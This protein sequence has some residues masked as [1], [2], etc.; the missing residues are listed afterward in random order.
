MSQREREP[1]A[2]SRPT[3]K[4]ALARLGATV[5]LG[6]A[7]IA[8]LFSTPTLLGGTE[9]TNLALVV[10]QLL[11][12]LAVGKL[13]AEILV[14]LRTRYLVTEQGVRREFSLLGRT[15]VKEVPYHRLRSTEREQNRIE[16]VLGVGSITL[17]QGLGDLRLTAVPDH[18]RLYDHI[19]D[20][21][22]ETSD[23]YS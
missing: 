15:R 9:R 22:G 3:I 13:L 16:Y 14:L 8:V 11:V 4:P 5:L 1:L 21:L 10:T 2:E 6:V 7:T 23:R 18:R 12:V 17:N 20:Q 19:R